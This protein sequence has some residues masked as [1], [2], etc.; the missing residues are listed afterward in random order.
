MATTTTTR[1]QGVNAGLGTKAPVLAATTAAITL[2]GAQTIDGVAVV[3]D[4]RVLVKDQADGAENGIYRADSSTWQR[5]YDWDGSFDVRQGT[6]IY[7]ASGSTN[8][9]LWAVTTANPITIGT[10]SLTIQRARL[11]QE[12]LPVACSD[13]GSILATG[14]KVA[15]RMPYAMALSNVKASLTAAQ[16]SGSLITVDVKKN[17]TSIFS[18]KITID[19]GEKTSVTALAPAVLSTTSLAADDEITIHLDQIG[20]GTATGLKVYLIG[21]Q[22]TA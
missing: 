11:Q 14:Q 20:D 2:S 13:E 21:L 12:S 9:G 7:V 4:D 18:T 1:R 3:A 19:N 8:Q 16:T 10:T 5:D 17:G 15:F 22:P 6:L